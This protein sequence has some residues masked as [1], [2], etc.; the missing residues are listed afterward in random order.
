MKIQSILFPTLALVLMSCGGGESHEQP[1]LASRTADSVKTEWLKPH[2]A[3]LCIRVDGEEPT[4]RLAG[5]TVTTISGGE[6]YEISAKAD[7]LMTHH[8]E[9]DY[10]VTP[11]EEQTKVEIQVAV[12]DTLLYA[13]TLL[14]H[15]LLDTRT[16]LNLSLSDKRLRM[17]SSWI[18]DAAAGVRE[19][20]TSL[21]TVRVGCYLEGDGNITSG[22]TATSIAMVIETD[23]RHGKAVALSDVGGEWIF[24]SQG[25]STGLTYET[26][27]GSTREGSLSMRRAEGDSLSSLSYYPG[28]SLREGALCEQDGYSLCRR[29]AAA[30]GDSPLTE[31]DMLKACRLKEGSYI[32]SAAEMSS[33]YLMA[34]G[35]TREKLTGPHFELPYGVYLTSSESSDDTCYAVDF[36]RGAVSGYNSKRY[37]PL[38]IRLFY[39]F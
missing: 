29:L 20:P 14:P 33:L 22:Y 17:V 8:Y 5:L 3:V 38:R 37:T 16:Q 12:N 21:D 6:S 2:E 13:A 24:S 19:A 9:R 27:D 1:L 30:T 15:L 10:A 32:P 36:G 28:C 39:I 35:Y 26:L 11:F 34:M 7:Q 4:D 23:G 18:E 31:D 25:C